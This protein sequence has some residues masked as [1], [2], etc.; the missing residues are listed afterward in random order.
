MP[1]VKEEVVDWVPRLRKRV[2]DLS[3]LT[4]YQIHTNS[5]T[6]NSAAC[7]NNA[8]VLSGT[9]TPL[10]TNLSCWRNKGAGGNKFGSLLFYFAYYRDERKESI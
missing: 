1:S 7:Q 2:L 10:L 3:L 6:Q 5:R 4:Q 8:L 9:L